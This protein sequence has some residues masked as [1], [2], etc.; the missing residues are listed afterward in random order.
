MNVARSKGFIDALQ[1][2]GLEPD[3]MN[4]AEFRAFLAT[5]LAKWAQ[6]VKASGAKLD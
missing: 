4:P 3:L 6:L 1:P 5:E 2:Q